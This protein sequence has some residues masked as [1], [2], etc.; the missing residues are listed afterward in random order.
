MEKAPYAYP[1]SGI[2]VLT[3]RAREGEGGW[4]GWGG[5]AG[6]SRMKHARTCLPRLR[7][8]ASAHTLGL[9]QGCSRLVPE[10]SRRTALA[11]AGISGLRRLSSLPLL[12]F[13]NVIHPRSLSSVL[14]I[15]TGGDVVMGCARGWGR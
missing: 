15:V 3:R 2:L 9:G 7:Q 5:G 4:P 12:S 14:R 6:G 8:A 10:R 13:E 11:S 1:R